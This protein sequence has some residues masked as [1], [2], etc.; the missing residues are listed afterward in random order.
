[1]Q[2]TIAAH[3]LDVDLAMMVKVIPNPYSKSIK[4]ARAIQI[5]AGQNLSYVQRT[6]TVK[7]G[8]S[9]KLTF[10]NPDVV[11]HN[12]VLVKPGALETVGQEANRLVADPEAVTHHYVPKSNDVLVYTDIVQPD[13]RGTIYFKAPSAKGRYPYLCTF[14]G[15][16]MVMNGVMIVE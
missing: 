2:K 10:N 11:P 6:I 9:I 12:L 14:P 3:P 7:A 16:W 4:D 1:M 13:T 15:H 5:D 8:E